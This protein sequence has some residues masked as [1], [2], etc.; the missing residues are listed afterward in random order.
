[1][2]FEQLRQKPTRTLLLS[3][4][5]FSSDGPATSLSLRIAISSVGRRANTNSIACNDDV[6]LRN[7]TALEA[8]E[9][10]PS[11]DRLTLTDAH[12]T[13]DAQLETDQRRLQRVFDGSGLMCI[14]PRSEEEF[15]TTNP[16]YARPRSLDGHVYERLFLHFSKTDGDHLVVAFL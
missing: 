11:P 14:L 16:C 12:K 4:I 2:P 1:M 8:V 7:S 15:E 9:Q 5:T 10:V 6:A 3:P 13:L